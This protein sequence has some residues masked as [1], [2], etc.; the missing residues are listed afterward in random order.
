M[1]NLLIS[2]CRVTSGRFEYAHFPKTLL[3]PHTFLCSPMPMQKSC[4]TRCVLYR[5]RVHCTRMWCASVS[6]QAF[7][8]RHFPY[9]P[10]CAASHFPFSSFV[11]RS[12]LTVSAGKHF[13]IARARMHASLHDIKRENLKSSRGK[14]LY[15]FAFYC[16]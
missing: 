12:F 15:C 6:M 9:T 13:H 4:E 5:W 7:S 3:A 10:V 11:S 8:H 16:Q 14:M 2:D 1:F